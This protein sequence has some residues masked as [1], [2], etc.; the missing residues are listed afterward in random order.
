MKK[1]KNIVQDWNTERKTFFNMPYIYSVFSNASLTIDSYYV[2]IILSRH[3]LK[4]HI[5]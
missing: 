2:V 4:P 3:S 1:Q 5:F